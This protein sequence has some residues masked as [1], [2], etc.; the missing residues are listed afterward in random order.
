MHANATVP[1]ATVSIVCVDTFG[2][3][4][5]TLKTFEYSLGSS[6][7]EPRSASPVTANIAQ[8][9]SLNTTTWT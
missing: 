8:L 9:I 5:S 7:D 4:Y 1:Y 6:S 2:V 3:L